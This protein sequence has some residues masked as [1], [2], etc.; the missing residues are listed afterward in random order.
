MTSPAEEVKDR[1][2]LV[3]VVQGYVRMSKAGK[4]W[5]GLCPF[6]AEKTA[7]FSVSPEKE[8]WYCFGCG[9]G[10][11]LFTFVQKIEN[12][13]FGEALRM[14]AEK[15]GVELKKEDPRVRSERQ[16]LYEIIELAAKF[17]EKQLQESSIGKKVVGYLKGR[18]L[19]G[20][21]I[22]NWRLG[23]APDNWSSLGEF[24]AERGYSDKVIESAG[25]SV[26]SASSPRQSASWHDRFR[27][28]VMFPIFDLH[29]QPVG[30]AGRVF[31]SVYGKTVGNEAGKYVNTP[32]TLI[33]DK[34][35]VLYGLDRAKNAIKKEGRATLVEGN[36]DLI[37]AHQVGTENTV[38]TSGTALTPGHL[39]LIKRYTAS[40]VLAFDPDEAGERATQRAAGLGASMDLDVH[41]VHLPVGKDA[42]D[43]CAT[44][45]ALWKKLLDERVPYVRF[46]LD[47]ALE[48]DNSETLEG[49]K[50]ISRNVL[51]AIT[52]LSSPL[53]REHWARELATL[54]KMSEGVINAELLRAEKTADQ[55]LSR[56]P[57]AESRPK[58]LGLEEYLIALLAIYPEGVDQA[59]GEADLIESVEFRDLIISAR[60]QKKN[61]AQVLSADPR[62][63][64][65]AARAAFLDELIADKKEELEIILLSLRH[66]RLK[67]KLGAV[68]ADLKKAE[69]NQNEAD[70]R[71][72]A[73]EFNNLS[74]ELLTYEQKEKANR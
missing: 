15:A 39:R 62:L 27:H 67:E 47:R 20:E 68:A 55:T 26:Q 70:A 16:V 11:D 18:G 66:R 46:V 59:A 36:L 65:L 14:L 44:D 54:L 40:V 30:F 13:D 5:K 73:A 56:N 17:Y 29:G 1:L 31:D 21:T 50:K 74:K 4:N 19:T 34:S 6:H 3:E 61:L 38:A 37:L 58:E 23:Y 8:M 49:K 32:N 10:G 12:V 42:A 43:V 69:H 45:P 2:N 57:Q 33:Y 9:E 7:S 48:R 63:A 60:D 71:S 53:E 72:L 51:S 24:L 25:L 41:V 64:I 28:R 35:G 52:L 22:S